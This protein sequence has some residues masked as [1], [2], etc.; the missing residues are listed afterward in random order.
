MNAVHRQTEETITTFPTILVTGA[1]G[2]IGG[3]LVKELTAHKVPFRAMVRRAKD[4]EALSRLGG[5]EAVIGNFDD[6]NT[7]A[8]ALQGVE[9]AFLLT[10]ST[11]RAE[12]QQKTFVDLAGRAGVTHIVKQSQWAADAD[13]P[14]R[15]LRYHAAVEKKLQASGLAYTF[16]RPNL[17]MQGLLGFRD[18]IVQQGKVFAAVGGA[19]VSAVDTRDVAEVAAA[20]L[21]GEGH[22]GRTYDLTGP[23]ALSH[24]EMAAKLS[25]ALGRTL[26]FVDVPPE[27]MRDTLLQVGFPIWQAGGLIEDYAHYARGEAA[28]VSGDTEEAT[29]SAPR[30]FGV[31]A[32]DYASAFS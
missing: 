21:T 10:P 26:E 14:V 2:N 1:T 6:E 29:G 12:A 19:K 25:A 32:R 23:E 3:E 24:A 9:R 18:T 15:F 4:A 20:A 27:A 28:V 13:S 5:V 22:A 31:F 30:S 17:F 8:D 16:L 7:L 11:E